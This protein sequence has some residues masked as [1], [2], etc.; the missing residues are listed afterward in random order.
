LREVK[1]LLEKEER[2]MET[3]KALVVEEDEKYFIEIAI[4]EEPIWIPLSEDKPNEVKSVFNK[5]IERMKEGAF[6]IELDQV[7]EDLFSQVAKEYLTQLN[8]EIEEVHDEMISLGL[9]EER[10]A[11][12]DD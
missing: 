11:I 6:E 2:F 5:L 8:L 7:G 9:V 12:S 4:E 10:E 3:V 1:K